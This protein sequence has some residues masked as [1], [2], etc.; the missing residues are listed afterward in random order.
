MSA[1]DI[2][3]GKD[4]LEVEAKGTVIFVIASIAFI[5]GLALGGYLGYKLG[6]KIN[7]KDN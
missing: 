4:G 5:G 3:V 1:L 6:K 2:E 7:K